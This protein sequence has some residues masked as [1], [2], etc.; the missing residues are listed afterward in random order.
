MVGRL[1]A[2]WPLVRPMT[3]GRGNS[4]TAESAAAVAELL[5]DSVGNLVEG[6]V[7]DHRLPGLCSKNRASVLSIERQS[8]CVVKRNIVYYK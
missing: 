2:A 7:V 3:R 5:L 6:T 8:I 1:S 4:P